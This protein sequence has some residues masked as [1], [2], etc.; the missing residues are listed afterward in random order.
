MKKRNR[1]KKKWKMWKKQKIRARW[2]K[3]KGENN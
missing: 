1:E 2:D 3:K